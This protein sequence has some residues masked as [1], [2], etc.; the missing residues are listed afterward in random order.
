[1][2]RE[3]TPSEIRIITEKVTLIKLEALNKIKSKTAALFA[4]HKYNNNNM[5]YKK[6]EFINKCRHSNKFLLKHVKKKQ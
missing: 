5:W 1:M 4:V 6:S 2:L 3:V